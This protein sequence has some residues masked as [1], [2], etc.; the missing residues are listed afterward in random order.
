MHI[1]CDYCGARIDTDVHKTCPNC[2]GSYS[3]DREVLDE[4]VRLDKIGELD[5]EKK[6]LEL[7]RMKIENEKLR[8]GGKANTAAKGCL[9][10]LVVFLCFLGVLFIVIMVIALSDTGEN[11]R[12]AQETL[13]RI[14]DLTYSFSMEPVP[15]PDVPDI[16]DIEIPD[17]SVTVTSVPVVTVPDISVPEM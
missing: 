17:I 12:K 8:K 5:I 3:N 16:P 15:V 10:P 13:H 2:G 7:E 9:I 6:R 11:D 14:S 1:F 4:K